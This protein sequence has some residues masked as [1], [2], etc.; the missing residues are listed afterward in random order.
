MARRPSDFAHAV[1]LSK[2]DRVGKRAR[3]LCAGVKVSAFAHPT[4]RF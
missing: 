4:K 3:E 1:S 2:W